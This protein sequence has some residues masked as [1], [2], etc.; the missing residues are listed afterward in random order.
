MTRLIGIAPPTG[1][2]S[3]RLAP[4]NVSFLFAAVVVPVVVSCGGPV[5]GD[6]GGTGGLAQGGVSGT[7]AG[8]LPTG[9]APAGGAPAGGAPTGGVP[10]GGT[11][12]ATTG[13]SG[14]SSAGGVAGS[15][16]GG[17]AGISGAA[18]SGVVAGSGGASAGTAGIGGSPSA[19]AGGSM[20][21]IA[22]SFV[23][24]GA[25][26][27]PNVPPLD[28]GGKGTAL[29]NHGPPS[30]RV[31][32]VI[33]ADGYSQSEL[34]ANGT[35]D[36]HLKTY[37]DKRFSA[38]IGQPYLRY[39]NFVNICVL[40]IASSA[41]CGSSTFGCC[42]SDSSRLATCNS[43]SVNNAIRDNLP[44]SFEVDWRAVVLNGSSWWNTGSSLMLW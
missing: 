20:G 41:I 28:C 1:G 38:V 18:G 40:R 25:G 9:G 44:A 5:D 27:M 33:V 16:V 13:G 17:A 29:E 34:A 21:G 3:M 4:L 7:G 6:E 36:A 26:G 30:N 8:G 24:G 35:L 42:G 22:G 11:S 2:L 15:G 32:Y 19:G 10:S 31:N 12:G 37:M 23:G 14:G 43:T 39:R